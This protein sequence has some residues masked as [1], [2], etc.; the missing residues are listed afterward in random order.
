M[1]FSIYLCYNIFLSFLR[2]LK[3]AKKRP[4]VFIDVDSSEDSDG[5][6]V[7][8]NSQSVCQSGGIDQS[9]VSIVLNL[10][11][12]LLVLFVICPIN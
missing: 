2:L 3:M 11:Y 12:I 6:H 5:F 4:K 9:D 8:H 1:L 10:L 7:E